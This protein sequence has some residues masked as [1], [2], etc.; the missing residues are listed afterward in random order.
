MPQET[1]DFEVQFRPKEKGI[2]EKEIQFETQLNPFEK[3]KL[4]L[5]GQCVYEQVGIENLDQNETLDF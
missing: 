1:C 4:T 2:Y 3:N 5:K